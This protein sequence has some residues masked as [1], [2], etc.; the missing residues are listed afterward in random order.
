MLN[1]I[2]EEGG[3]ALAYGAVG[4]ALLALGFLVVEV[5]TPGRLGRQI[6][7]E[8]NAG[9]AL[10]LAAKLIGL[11]AI[12]TTAIATSEE[13]LA[14]GLVSTAAY[15]VLG[16]ILMTLAFYLLD[17]LTPGK[18]GAIVVG[19]EGR[20]PADRMAPACWVVAATDLAIAAIVS[21]AIA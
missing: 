11:G 7:S 12:V 10:I 6:W 16:I 9:A 18:L 21:A 3:A 13:G 15:G 17:L 1:T 2:V 8:H 4:I 20:A 19:R 5:T 14:D